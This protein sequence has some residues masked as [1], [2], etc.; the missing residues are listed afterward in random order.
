MNCDEPFIVINPSTQSPTLDRA[1]TV[2][3]RSFTLRVVDEEG[4]RPAENE[5]DIGTTQMNFVDEVSM[6]RSTL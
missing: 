6:Y 1:Q 4:V 5:Y 3:L 2:S